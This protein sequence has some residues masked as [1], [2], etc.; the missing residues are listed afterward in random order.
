[1]SIEE[2]RVVDVLWQRAVTIADA[3]FDL[4]RDAPNWQ[5]V[6]TMALGH[7]RAHEQRIRSLLEANNREVERR[8][9]AERVVR[10]AAEFEVDLSPDCD[11][12]ARDELRVA[13]AAYLA[14]RDRS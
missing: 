4:N 6:H 3:A 2:Q 13:L 9:V 5:R 11:G 1:M 14:L 10:S 7:L 8:R 12:P